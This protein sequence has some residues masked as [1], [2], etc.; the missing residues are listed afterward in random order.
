MKEKFNGKMKIVI[1]FSALFLVIATL[2]FLIFNEGKKSYTV[3]FDLDGG[4]LLNGSLEQ[5]II[6]GQDANPPTVVKDGAYLH[7][8]SASCKHI[9][10]DM[11]IKAV[12]EYET[13]AGVIYTDS[14][15]QNYTEIAGAFKHLQGEVYLGAYHDDKKV[16]GICDGA[17]SDCL[18]ITKVYLLDG[19]LSIG[20]NAFSGCT[21]LAEIEIPETVVRVGGGAFQNC[22]A[23]EKLVLNEGLKKIGPNAFLGCASLTE[24][25]IPKTVTVLGYGAFQNCE[26]LETLVLSEG[27]EEIGANAF[28]GCT[29]LKTVI[30]PKSL[31]KIDADAFAGCEGLIIKVQI[32]ENEIPEGWAEGWNGNAEIEWDVEVDIEEDIEKEDAVEDEE[33]AA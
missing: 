24:V 7:S 5:T 32:S 1:I 10:K 33:T 16:L 30:L 11:V 28:A 15:N 31:K 18:G 9:T 2:L 6:H 25:T 14:E 27:I 12:W 20:L 13:T 8:W 4:T 26:S 22:E 23:L 17:F 21:S 19:L 29:E 3:T